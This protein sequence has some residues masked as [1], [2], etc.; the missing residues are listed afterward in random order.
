MKSAPTKSKNSGRYEVRPYKLTI[1]ANM[2]FAPTNAKNS[3][4]CEIRPY[5]L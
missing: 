4:R 3:G 2:K 5:K 1:R